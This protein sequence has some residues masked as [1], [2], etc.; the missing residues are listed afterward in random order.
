MR[1]RQLDDGTLWTSPPCV[2]PH[3]THNIGVAKVTSSP[4]GTT[5]GDECASSATPCGS[6]PAFAG[7]PF[8]HADVTATCLLDDL[9][10]NLRPGRRPGPGDQVAGPVADIL[11]VEAVLPL[12]G[13]PVLFAPV[14]RRI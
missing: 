2:V 12:P 7:D 14:P 4:S 11:L 8:V 9:R 6:G 10:G 1:T 3:V 5:S 13:N